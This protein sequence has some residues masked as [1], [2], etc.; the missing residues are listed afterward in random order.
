MS[1]MQPAEEW[2]VLSARIEGLMRAS[3]LAAS[4]LKIRTS[5]EYRVVE[6][7]LV[8][9]MNTLVQELRQF[10]TEHVGTLPREAASSL[11]RFLTKWQ[12]QPTVNEVEQRLLLAVRLG[13]FRSEF[14]F[15]LSD[16]ELLA[17][18]ATERTFEHLNRLL[19]VDDQVRA[20]WKS[21][22]EESGEVACERLGAVHLLH[23]GI[24]AFKVGTKDAATDLVFDEPI[25]P[26][27][28]QARR[29]AHALVLTEWKTVKDKGEIEKKAGE[30]RKQAE[31]YAG[32]AL[33]G[34]ELRST[35]YV[36]LVSRDDIDEAPPDVMG[37]GGVRYRH[38][39]IPIERPT[40]SKI[41]RLPHNPLKP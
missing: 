25:E 35:R 1:M 18:S 39:A 26:Y 21:A 36:V 38:I 14:E 27:L 6:D 5:D 34:L 24:W 40:P 10:K 17:T 30:A 37:A 19:T 7:F 3:E 11:D 33:G 23:H 20:R 4:V 32:G 12:K 22:F 2:R 31:Q 15:L 41:A 29:V 28:S 16:S 13:V 9:E 8:P